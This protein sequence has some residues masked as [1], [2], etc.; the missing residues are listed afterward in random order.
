MSSPE[1]QAAKT[2]TVSLVGVN[3]VVA[4]EGEMKQGVV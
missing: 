3:F 1:F 4:I 2:I